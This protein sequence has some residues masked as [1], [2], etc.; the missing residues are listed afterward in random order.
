MAEDLGLLDEETTSSNS[1]TSSQDYDYYDPSI[2]NNDLRNNRNNGQFF[3]NN[4]NVNIYF[5]YGFGRNNFGFNP[6]FDPYWGYGWNDPFFN[7]YGFGYGYG[8]GWGYGPS[9]GWGSPYGFYDPWNPWN[10]WNRWR[11]NNGPYGSPYGYCPSYYGGGNGWGNGGS[12][13]QP[14]AGTGGRT[15]FGPTPNRFN[16]PSG[17]RTTSGSGKRDF[18]SST[19]GVA[20]NDRPTVDRSRT[21]SRL[22]TLSPEFDQPVQTG[23]VATRGNT[24]GR[25]GASPSERVVIRRASESTPARRPVQEE[26]YTRPVR[27]TEPSVV[28]RGEAE[29]V[30]RPSNNTREWNQPTRTVEREREAAPSRGSWWNE[31]TSPSRERTAPASRPSRNYEPASRSQ[32]SRNVQPQRSRTTPSIN[33][34]PEQRSRN[35][36]PSRRESSPSRNVSPSRSRGGNSSGNSS[37]SSNVVRRR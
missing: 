36:T 10:R 1:S 4:P 5:G 12:V 32:P 31:N 13:G 14:V 20:T 19:S 28:S 37:R 35:V 34:E 26:R 16:V 24:V 18:P 21:A 23:G 25:G 11:Y 30:R 17:G 8:Y 9:W 27:M 6:Y 22:R 29:P 33:R 2:V 3:N 7:P 15:Y